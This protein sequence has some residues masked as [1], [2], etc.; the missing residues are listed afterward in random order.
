ME[1]GPITVT[2]EGGG[3]KVSGNKGPLGG[4]LQRN[5]QPGSKF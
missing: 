3:G 2:V 5:H 1:T 4:Q